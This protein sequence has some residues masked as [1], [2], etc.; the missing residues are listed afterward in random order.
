M[1]HL[2]ELIF[3]IDAAK[4]IAG[5]DAEVARRI[6][7][8]RQRINDWRKGNQPC[9]PEHQ[10]LLAAVA[11]FDPTTTVLRAIVEKHEGTEL[12]DRLMRVLGK[13]LRATGAAIGFAGASALAIYSLTPTQANARAVEGSREHNVHNRNRSYVKRRLTRA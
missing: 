12:G 13:A 5:S 8:P 1:E 4:K 7:Q 9:P 2:D 3:L 10:A 11:G 6:G